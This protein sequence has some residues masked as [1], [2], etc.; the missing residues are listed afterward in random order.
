MRREEAGI[1]RRSFL[2]AAVPCLGAVTCSLSNWPSTIDSQVLTERGRF[3]DE[4]LAWARGELLK[5]VNSERA[6]AG[7]NNLQLDELACRVANDHATD[8]VKGDFLSHWGSDGLKPYQ[9]YSF[10]GGI[11][12]LK[13]NVSRQATSSLLLPTG[14][15]SDLH[16]MHTKM[17]GE[18]PPYD[19]HRQAIMTPQNTHVGFGI[20]LKGRSLK[21]SEMYLAR[22]LELSP[23]PQ[24]AKRKATVSL[25]G[26]LLSTK[27][28]LYEVDIFYE[29]PPEIPDAAW[30]HLPQSYSY[31]NEFTGLRP[32]APFGATY[33]DGSTGDFEWD[34]SGTFRVPAKLSKNAAGIYTIMFWIQRFSED[35]KF[36]AAQVCIRA[37]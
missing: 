9:R 19:G 4:D 16:D 21:L 5:L 3:S 15:L 36:P 31:P 2:K 32:K 12:G 13:E 24:T 17:H 27:Y 10:A 30:L 29:P 11:D 14:V 23:F 20:A 7:M 25:T 33:T 28:S 26:K 1:H 37:E 8:M 18:K 35:K 6:A 22:Y 34:R